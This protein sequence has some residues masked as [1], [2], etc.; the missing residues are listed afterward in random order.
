MAPEG[1]LWRG[2]SHFQNSSCVYLEV[3]WTGRGMGIHGSG[4]KVQDGNSRT[5]NEGV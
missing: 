3:S 5:G 2:K 1:V 4:G